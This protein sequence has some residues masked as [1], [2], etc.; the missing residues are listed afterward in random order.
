[1]NFCT[2]SKQIWQA[3][4]SLKQAKAKPLS[5]LSFFHKQLAQVPG[6]D[7][8]DNELSVQQILKQDGILFREGIK[9]KKAIV[10]LH[11]GLSQAMQFFHADL[12]GGKNGADSLVKVLLANVFDFETV[13]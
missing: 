13:G 6:G 8:A 5:I 3:E 11:L 1:L 10:V 2:K 12:W 4:S 9:A 7:F